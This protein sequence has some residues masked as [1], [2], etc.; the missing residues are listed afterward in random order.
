MNPLISKES[1]LKESKKANVS[2]ESFLA[3]DA[4]ANNSVDAEDLKDCA[5]D[6]LTNNLENNLV[7]GSD[8]DPISDDKCSYLSLDTLSTLI[9]AFEKTNKKRRP[10]STKRNKK[11]IA[12]IRSNNANR[13]DLSATVESGSSDANGNGQSAAP[14]IESDSA[15]VETSVKLGPDGFDENVAAKKDTGSKNPT[16]FSC[17]RC[18]RKFCQLRNLTAHIASHDRAHKVH[19]C[20]VRLLLKLFMKQS[21]ENVLKVISVLCY[22]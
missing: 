9:S 5:L 7:N 15:Q 19:K 2:E 20:L 8:L 18:P 12:K 10:G 22:F 3:S 16:R 1:C 13:Y 17:S 21:I 6:N 14:D 11:Q 4:Y